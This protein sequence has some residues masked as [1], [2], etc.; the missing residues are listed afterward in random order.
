[1]NK[2]KVDKTQRNTK[3]SKKKSHKMDVQKLTVNE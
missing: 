2:N 1:M 3:Y